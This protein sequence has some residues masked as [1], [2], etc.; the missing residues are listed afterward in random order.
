MAV[1]YSGKQCATCEF[2]DGERE[3]WMHQRASVKDIHKEGICT[4]LKSSF[5][6]KGTSCS[7][8]CIKWEKW[9]SLTRMK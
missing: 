8:H 4:N 5:K 1:N 2:W 6:K 3:D 7:H 9:E